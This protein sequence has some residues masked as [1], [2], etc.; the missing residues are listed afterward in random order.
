MQ[1]V[2]SAATLTA[3]LRTTFADAYKKSYESRLERLKKVMEIGLPSD[4]RT[5][6]YAYFETAPY[7]KRWDRGKNISSK[8]FKSNDF[9]VTNYNWGRRISWSE[10]DRDDDQT[11]TLFEQAK[12]LGTNFGTRHERVFFQI[13]LAATNA[14]LLP[15]IP[16]APDGVATYSATDGSGAARFGATGGNIVSGSGV[17]TARAIQVD[18]MDAIERFKA[19]QDTEGEPLWD[20]ALLDGAGYLLIYNVANDQLV[21]EALKTSTIFV[22]IASATSPFSPA[23]A[24][25]ANIVTE[26]GIKLDFWP[27]QRISTDDIYVFAVGSPHKAV[28]HQE[29]RGLRET[30]ANVDNSDHVRDTKEEYLQYDSRDGYGAFLPYQTVQIDNP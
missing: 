28:F 13:I 6:P 30:F 23:A 16:N 15:A 10:D 20:E 3:G 24:A 14:D 25:P 22:S 11:K 18:V 9:S 21:K 7:P 19:F 12:M 8:P 29:R 17:A 27:T 5:E 2:I 26:E 1:T 4:K